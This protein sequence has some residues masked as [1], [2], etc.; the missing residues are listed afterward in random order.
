MSTCAHLESSSNTVDQIDK[1]VVALLKDVHEDIFKFM[2]EGMTDEEII[3]HMGIGPQAT[4]PL[5]RVE[6]A[7]RKKNHKKKG[8]KK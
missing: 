8:K 6:Y 1:V 2:D 7:A 3:N 5:L 4:L